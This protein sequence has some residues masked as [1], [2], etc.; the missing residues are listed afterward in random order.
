MSAKMKGSCNYEIVY[1]DVYRNASGSFNES[2]STVGADLIWHDEHFLMFTR[3][4][5]E[6]MLPYHRIVSV[7]KNVPMSSNIR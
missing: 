4:N 1:K 3:D 5:I 2:I 6:V 7:A